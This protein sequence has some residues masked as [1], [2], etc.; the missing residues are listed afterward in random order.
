MSPCEVML[1]F[2]QHVVFDLEIESVVTN[3]FPLGIAYLA[4]SLER[5]GVAVQVVDMVT[6][7]ISIPTLLR[8]IEAAA[9]KLVG[10]SVCT[11]AYPRSLDIARAIKARFPDIQVVFG[12]AHATVKH[13]QVMEEEAVDVAVI[14]EGEQTIVELV[15]ARREGRG[16]E[17]ILGIAYR[18]DGKVV[19]N[20]RRPFV[21]DLD[22]LAPPA[23]HYFARDGRLLDRYDA[24]AVCSGRGCTYTCSFCAAGALSG[25]AYRVRSPEAI[26]REIEH[27]AGEF[28]VDHFFIVDDTFTAI[29]ERAYALCSLLAQRAP[30]IRWVC[31]CRTNTV[32]RHLLEKMAESGCYKLQFGI[33]SG[34]QEILN[35]VLKGTTLRQIEEAVRNSYLA[36]ISEV[37]GSFIIGLPGE[38]YETAMETIRFALQLKAIAEELT[39]V[40]GKSH[41]FTPFLA[42]LIPFPSTVCTDLAESLG[43]D[44]VRDDPHAF[45]SDVILSNPR[46]IGPKEIR[47]LVMIG[48]LVLQNLRLP[49]LKLKVEW[50][51]QGELQPGVA[52]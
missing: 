30:G 16:L 47:E 19:V 40:T 23:V 21:R 50:P 13:R 5:E 33:E 17:S 22:S 14:G 6:D 43:I 10:I 41:R 1:V 49:G 35:G 37:V 7:C 44:I 8:R 48:Q 29:P 27:V 4:G 2:P 46:C 34:N 11:V 38:T 18:R 32:S 3:I 26:V 12:G 31:E 36:G 25:R 24:Y 15:R 28:G 9:P 45:I 42:S 39:R 52:A 51:V 20:P